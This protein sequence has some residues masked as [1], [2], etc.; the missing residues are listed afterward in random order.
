M[1]WVGVIGIGSMVAFTIIIALTTYIAI[2]AVDVS[3]IQ[4]TPDMTA[5][6]VKA[7]IMNDPTIIKLQLAEQAFNRIMAI[8]IGLVMPIITGMLGLGVYRTYEKTKGVSER[9]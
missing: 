6:A 2:I 1:G 4:V 7:A 8:A 5:E 3:D 9:K